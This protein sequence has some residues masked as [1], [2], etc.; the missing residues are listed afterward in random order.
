MSKKGLGDRCRQLAVSVVD[1]R[2]TISRLETAKLDIDATDQ[3]LE[4]LRG[5][6]LISIIN[7]LWSSRPY[8]LTTWS[9]NQPFIEVEMCSRLLYGKTLPVV[10]KILI[11]TNSLLSL[12]V[13]QPGFNEGCYFQN[14]IAFFFP[15]IIFVP[16]AIIPCFSLLFFSLFS[17]RFFVSPPLFLP[18]SPPLLSC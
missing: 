3:Q 8:C 2:K 17:Y 6:E 4:R 1:G 12:S 5:T 18:L 16:L 7:N 15:W 11:M 10:I 9:I 14:T 13:V